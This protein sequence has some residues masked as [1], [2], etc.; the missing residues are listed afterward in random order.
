MIDTLITVGDGDA[1]LRLADVTTALNTAL[2]AL[3]AVDTDP[4]YRV[5]GTSA[6][7]LQGVHLPVGDIDLLATRREDVDTSL[8]LSQFFLPSRRPLGSPKLR[9]TTPMTK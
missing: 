4:V 3:R 9:S 8:P 6:A 2:T 5:V 1:S 7:L